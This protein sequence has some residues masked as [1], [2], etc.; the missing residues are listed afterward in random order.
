M[1]CSINGG[2][3]PVASNPNQQRSHHFELHTINQ[4]AKRSFRLNGSA[5]TDLQSINDIDW[6]AHFFKDVTYKDTRHNIFLDEAHGRNKSVTHL[7]C[8]FDATAGHNE[9]NNSFSATNRALHD[10]GALSVHVRQTDDHLHQDY[11]RL[12]YVEERARRMKEGMAAAVVACL[13]GVTSCI[14]A[15]FCC[16]CDS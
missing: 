2:I 15:C 8:A 16:C 7:S 13:E 5:R 10:S 6:S 3:I 1:E 4:P 14:V 12:M 9:C 11:W